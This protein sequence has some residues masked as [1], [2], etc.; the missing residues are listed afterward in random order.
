M[1]FSYASD[2][3]L[4]RYLVAFSEDA[5]SETILHVYDKSGTYPLSAHACK[6]IVEADWVHFTSIW[7][8]FAARDMEL[9]F[10]ILWFYIILKCY[11]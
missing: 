3:C 8:S 2:F 5:G 11:F 4:S 9:V 7:Q 10:K 1:F 6:D